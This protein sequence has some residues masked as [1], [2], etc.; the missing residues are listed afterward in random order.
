MPGNRGPERSLEPDAARRVRARRHLLGAAGVEPEQIPGRICGLQAQVAEAAGLALLARTDADAASVQAVLAGPRLV[1][2]WAMRG[3][4]H[5]VDREDLRWYAAAV[6]GR[7][8]ARE[9]RLWPRHGVSTAHEERVTGAILRALADG[10]LERGELAAR[11]GADLG[12]EVE[13]LLRHPWGIGIKPAVA[14]GLVELRSRGRDMR[15]S[16]PDGPVET[17]DGAQ[18]RRWLA[19]RYLSANVVGDRASFARWSGLTAA[20]A[21]DA[22]EAAA[23]TAM[24]SGGADRYFA[25]DLTDPGPSDHVSFLPVFDPFTLAAADRAGFWPGA[26]EAVWRRGGW[27]S[28]VVVRDGRALGTW[29]HRK[30]RGRIT[31]S[32]SWSDEREEPARGLLA[33][34]EARIA[35]LLSA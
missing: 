10:P 3:T 24:R 33:A 20:Q 21:G 22:L 25:G 19:R 12:P 6:G 26:P 23:D 5:L 16:L 27:V 8:A 7:I 17:V 35:E 30:D 15:L 29:K 18:A 14:A 34:G 1:L 11:V 9:T 28:A 32:Y 2:T 4:L 31:F 13:G